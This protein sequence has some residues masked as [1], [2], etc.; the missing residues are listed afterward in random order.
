MSSQE[1]I[2]SIGL[3]DRHI[4][5][6]RLWCAMRKGRESASFEYDQD[7]LHHPEK[8]A[9]EPALKL[10]VGTFH[11]RAGRSVFG[12]MG[13][14]APDRWGRVLMRR[15]HI[16]QCKANDTTPS[17]LSE[18]D[19]LLG[20]SD[21]ARQGALRFS[22]PEQP[23]VFLASNVQKAIPPLVDLPRLLGATDRF[24]E[25]DESD[26]DLQLLLA[27]GSSL[28]GARPKAS[29]RDRDGSLAIAKF[30][31][32]DDEYNLVAWE[33]VALTLA[34]DAGIQ[35]PAFRLASVV[36]KQILIVQ[37]FDR[38]STTRIPFL[39]AMSM[40]DAQDNEPHSYLELVYA[41]VQY[42]ASPKRDME[43][44]WRRI[45]FMIMIANTDDHLR[46]HGF[47]Y[48]RHHGWR[49]CPAYDLNP[50]PLDIKPRILTTAI[51]LDDTNASLETALKVAGEFRLS[52][53]R[54]QEIIQEVKRAVR[55]WRAVATQLGLSS[56]EC[57]RMASAFLDA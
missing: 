57:D 24:L 2:V 46:N 32:K 3:G 27:P 29:I 5:V 40:L 44:L 9:L 21:E 31:R 48:E 45:V 15:A 6:G 17:T 56:A 38:M 20:V 55:R 53:K 50:T 28:G 8:F 39:S 14:S 42:G 10:T 16:A 54:A 19:Y 7:W 36:G 30:S 22:L 52:P 18:L 23:E 33:A 11:T 37:R 13:D 1:V 43:A 34:R 41:L 47:I 12:A 25:E 35:V 26:I 4:R 51:D 49:L